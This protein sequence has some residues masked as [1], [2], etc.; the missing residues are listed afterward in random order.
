MDSKLED[1]KRNINLTEY[2]A[3]YGYVF[4]KR[5]SRANSAVMVK[6]GDKLI[7]AKGYTG[8]WIC[9]SV[10]DDLDNGTILDFHQKRTG[11]SLIAMRLVH[12]SVAR[13]YALAKF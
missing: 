9:F 2:M 10:R 6:G 13:T 8:F 12:K 1:F 11:D 4:C 3:A 5:E 7:V